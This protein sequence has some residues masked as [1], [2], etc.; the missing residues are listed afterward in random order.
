MEYYDRISEVRRTGNYEQW[1][2]FFLEAVSA[3]AKDSLATVKDLSA[4]HERN[5]ALLPQSRRATDSLRTLFAYVE[6]FPIIDIRKT[7]KELGFSYNTVSAAVKKLMGL[8]ILRETTNAQ[9]NRVF[10]YEEYLAILRRDIV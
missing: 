8:G 10:A 7:A 5:V 4:L 1:V 9:R 2:R 6:Q 3:A